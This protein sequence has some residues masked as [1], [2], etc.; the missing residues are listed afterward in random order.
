MPLFA[1]LSAIG[2]FSQ[3]LAPGQAAG[4]LIV[5]GQRAALR[6]AYAGLEPNPFDSA[7]TD[8][9][10]VLTDRPIPAD[11]LAS[12]EIGGLPGAA[13]AAKI[14]NY[15]RIKLRREASGWEIGHRTISH[16]VLKGKSLQIS[17]D[18]VSKFEGRTVTDTR[19]E[20]SI[21]SNGPQTFPHDDAHEYKISFNAEVMP[22]KPAAEPSES[23]KRSSNVRKGTPLPGGGGDP[24]RALLAYCEALRKGDLEALQRTD[25]TLAEA[26]ASQLEDIRGLLQ[27]MKAGAPEDVKILRGWVQDDEALLEVQ[28]VVMGQKVKGEAIMAR[29]GGAWR[30][31]SVDWN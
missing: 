15:L 20:G 16:D 12:H 29:A 10:V 13:E 31:V 1:L 25:V 9:V 6:Y 14:R 28:G 21:Q 11:V 18:L 30:V 4:T 17:P 8:I 26:T 27:I 19:V 7:K 2:V 24:G 22:L 3:T 5:N 23:V